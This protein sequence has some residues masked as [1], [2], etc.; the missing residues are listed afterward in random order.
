MTMFIPTVV[1]IGYVDTKPLNRLCGFVPDP[2]A[3]QA[4]CRDRV[5]DLSSATEPAE[6]YAYQW[7]LLW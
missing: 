7:P 4:A 6:I 1:G 3:C 5:P 2:K